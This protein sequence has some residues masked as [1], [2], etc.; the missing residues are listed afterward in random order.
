MRRFAI[1]TILS[2][3]LAGCAT[4]SGRTPET[5]APIQAAR[6]AWLAGNYERALPLLKR[7]ARAGN[8][9]AQYALGYM[10]YKGQGVAQNMRTALVWIRRAADNDSALAIEALG[11]IA[12]GSLTDNA[13]PEQQPSSEGEDEKS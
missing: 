12:S 10:Y 1:I 6:Q 8:P 13:S 4:T 9:R 5:V 7:L 11:R 3:A 2:L